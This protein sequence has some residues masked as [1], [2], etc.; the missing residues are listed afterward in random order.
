M[1]GKVFDYD[2]PVF[3]F[4]NTLAN[5]VILSVV[6]LIC[7]IPVFTFG[8]AVRAL[9][10]VSLKM[11]RN[12][13]GY[14][15]KD[16][17]KSFRSNFGQNV[18]LGLLVLLALGIFGGGLYAFI[19]IGAAYHIII[20]IGFGFAALIVISTILWIFPMQSRFTNP[21]RQTIKLSFWLAV[22]KFPK[23]LLMLVIW[24]FIPACVVFVSGNFFPLIFL[25][26]LGTAAYF[27]AEVYDGL[28]RELEDRINEKNE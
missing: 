23:T 3:R 4:L 18:V 1:Q 10:A 7:C 12:E 26:E 8:P 28:F 24:L 19:M 11:V 22:T 20:K 14:I 21:I 25:A 15:L 9:F 16:Y 27:S 5:V 17:F 13:E 2:G 6:T